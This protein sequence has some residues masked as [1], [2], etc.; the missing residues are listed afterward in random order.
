MRSPRTVWRRGAPSQGVTLSVAWVTCAAIAWGAPALA[1]AVEVRVNGSARLSVDVQAAGTAL[2]ISGVLRD[3]VG[4]PL[5]RR[6]LDLLIER[7]VEED[8]AQAIEVELDTDMQ[9]RFSLQRELGPGR[10]RVTL[11]FAPTE[12]FG[13]AEV[14]RTVELSAVPARLQMQHPALVVGRGQ[15]AML[16]VRASVN[17]IG[18]QAPV[19]L[20]FN[21][22]SVASLELDRFGRGAFDM[23][24]FLLAGEQRVSAR[25]SATPSRQEVLEEASIVY[26]EGVEVRA[27]LEPSYRRLE[28]GVRV[29]G[30]I[31]DDRS[32]EPLGAG[33]VWVSFERAPFESE[34]F[35]PFDAR[36][37]RVQVRPGGEFE[38]FL[39]GHLLEDG[40]WRAELEYR[41]DVGQGAHVVT[42]PIELDRRASRALMN[43]IG[44][45]GLLIGLIVLA[46]RVS[47]VDFGAAWKRLRGRRKTAARDRELEEHFSN[48]ERIVVEA[49]GGESNS[50]ALTARDVGGVVW[51]LW[52]QRPIERATIRL[53]SSQHESRTAIALSTGRFHIEAL[54]PGRW[55]MR[56]E[57]SGFAPGTLEVTI[58]H[59]GELASFKLGLVAIPLK[60]KRFYKAWV[61][62]VQG[63]D[64]WGVLSPR[65][66]ELAITEALGEAHPGQGARDKILEAL[67]SYLE[68]R[69]IEA[70]LDPSRLLLS[71]TQIVEEAYFSG[72]HQ[73][74]SLWTLLVALTQRLDHA[75]ERV[76]SEQ[77]WRRGAPSR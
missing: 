14:S 22:Q 35:S 70:E 71:I 32:G 15:P 2:Q 1:S 20:S 75:F 26:A 19:T 13:G 61:R 68:R 9:G 52:R 73:D 31:L 60:I 6:D 41:P 4:K 25:L 57:A 59:G 3:E 63:R 47:M 45:L 18:V 77:A 17:E 50:A 24:P 23:A 51:D 49:L 38:A 44:L 69:D 12:H 33:E 7:A 10:V 21:G 11:A 74:E 37:Q 55:Q 72:R 16:R 67:S 53:T 30:V 29:Y 48:E 56:V 28:R 43:V 46:W 42:A 8:G 65:Q 66:I 36:P 27:S 64:L 5:P 39:A 76:A 58:P 40:R 54:E 62:R 34:A